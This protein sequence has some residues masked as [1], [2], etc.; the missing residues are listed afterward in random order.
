MKERLY[1]S[2]YEELNTGVSKSYLLS[3]YS[4]IRSLINL[5]I[6]PDETYP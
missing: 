6:S 4:E 1:K 3:Q 2:V 5:Q